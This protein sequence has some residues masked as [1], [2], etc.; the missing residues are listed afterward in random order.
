MKGSSDVVDFSDNDVAGPSTS[1]QRN[2][3]E[4]TMETADERQ[5][6]DPYEQAYLHRLDALDQLVDEK[7]N[8][9]APDWKTEDLA[10][11]FA[12]TRNSSCTEEGVRTFINVFANTSVEDVMLLLNQMKDVIFEAENTRFRL[13]Q[14]KPSESTRDLESSSSAALQKL[15]SIIGQVNNKR[16]CRTANSERLKEALKSFALDDLTQKEYRASDDVFS[17]ACQEDESISYA[18]IYNFLAEAAIIRK[19]KVK[20][21]PLESAILWNIFEEMNEIADQNFD[22]HTAYFHQLLRDFQSMSHSDLSFLQLP[23]EDELGKA[24]WNTL[25][26][27]DRLIDLSTSLSS[28]PIEST[29]ET[30]K[31]SD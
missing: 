5:P 19:P 11:L 24:M 6:V 26:L 12:R 27:P 15:V 8:E 13:D 7:C 9:L 14:F 20:L 4:M 25:S 1:R 17:P 30:A 10:A 29:T 31:Q 18:N 28:Q 22:K 21:Q 3:D 2:D 16:K 23:P